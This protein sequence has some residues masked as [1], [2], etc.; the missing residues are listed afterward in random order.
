MGRKTPASLPTGL[1]YNLLTARAPDETMEVVTARLHGLKRVVRRLLR[2]ISMRDLFLL[3]NLNR[4]TA[5]VVTAAGNKWRVMA[6]E[7]K[8]FEQVRAYLQAL[9]AMEAEAADFVEMKP[10]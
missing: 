5:V 7:E 4:S 2:T 10:S 6:I 3:L 1:D 8:R 9:T